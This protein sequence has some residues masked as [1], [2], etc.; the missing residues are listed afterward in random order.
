MRNNTPVTNV[1]YELK[2]GLSIV[3]KTDLKG[4]I[5]Y[6]NHDFVEASGYTEKELIGQPHNIL[7]HP[8]MPVEAFADLWA[9]L[10]AGKPWTGIVK[11]RR[12]N[13]DHYWVIANAAPLYENGSRVGYMS[14]RSKPTRAQIEAHEAA[15]RLFR[16]GKQGDLRIVEG[17][18]VKKN[19]IGS[20]LRSLL[21][22]SEKS[23]III[24]FA[25]LMVI[26]IAVILGM[27]AV[28][29]NSML[30][31]RQRAT[32]YAVE[33]AWGTVDSLGKSAAA[34]EISVEE[35]QKRA[36]AQLKVMRYDSKEYFW[37]N[38]MQPHMIIQPNQN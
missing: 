37:I 13:G 32:R 6:A 10:Q 21:G 9:T 4:V 11:N 5:T 1:E 19:G 35:A 30:E 25:S 33:T 14:A 15:Y 36:I 17:K 23:K 26:F 22:K 20:A 3:S 31:D 34:G 24:T 28:E 27:L 16:E 7:R 18:A 29:R 8:D 2:D 12:K 38:D